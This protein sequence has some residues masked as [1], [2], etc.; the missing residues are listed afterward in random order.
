[1]QTAA[2]RH[3]RAEDVHA[4]RRATVRY[5]P[6]PLV[7]VLFAHRHA[8]NPTAGLLADVS[9]GGCRIMAPPTARPELHWGD[10]FRIVVSYSESSRFAGVEGMRLAAHVVRLVAD[11]HAL[12]VHCQFSVDGHDGDWSRLVDWIRRMGQGQG[13]APR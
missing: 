11:A 7:P 1:M 4:E 10:P 3:R 12:I 9:L 6:D 5:S 13:T 2:L 8:E